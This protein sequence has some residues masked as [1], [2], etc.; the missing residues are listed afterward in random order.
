MASAAA[1][2]AGPVMRKTSAA[3]GE[4]PF[5][6]KAAAMGTEA[7]EHTYTGIP[8]ASMASMDT[9]PGLK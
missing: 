2:V 4:M 6:I 9:N 1:L 5:S 7:V 8:N 3:P